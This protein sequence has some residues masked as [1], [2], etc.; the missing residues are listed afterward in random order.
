[1]NYAK[2]LLDFIQKSPSC[3]HAIEN[4]KNQLMEKG[5]T[6]LYEKED[7]PLEA[8]KKYFVRRN[9][10]AIISFLVPEDF[11]GFLITASHSDSPTF[12]IKENPE[13]KSE[14]IISL[15]V[16]KYGG[17][18]IAPWFD[19]PLSIAGRIV[20]SSKDKENC[21]CIQEK[22]I[23]FD[24]DL[25]MIPNL[26][27]HMNR[28]A[29]SGHEFDVQQ[30][31]RPIISSEEKFSFLELIAKEAGVKKEEILSYDLYL[32]NRD[33]GT[34]WGKDKE[35]ISSPKLDDLE[36]AYTVLQGFIDAT[37]DSNKEIFQKNKKA[38]VYSVFDNEEVGSQSRQGAASTFL[39]DT[40]KRINEIFGRS[41][42]DYLKALANSF[43]VSA[44]N[45]H[46]VHPNYASKADPNNKP[47]VNAGPVIK[48]NAAQKYTSDALSSAIF[49]KVCNKAKLPYQIFTN[50]S[51]LAGG[52]T[53]GNISESQVSI[54][55]VD[56][57]LAQWAMHSPNESGGAKD[58]ELMI[59]AISEYYKND[60]EIQ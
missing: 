13:L 8:G 17:M 49:K 36:C 37:E 56:I 6:E 23:N 29:N 35:F 30:E 38:L 59:K 7:W 45:A 18:L 16:E 57:G 55:S 15:N 48:F 32:Y 39:K 50:N 54:L 27:I 2:N 31:I 21:L 26:A 52:S 12:K 1:M 42:K 58:V 10:S 51:N 41:E 40:L 20:L 22:L 33:K 47:Q 4:I 43:L 46:A 3:F 44:D 53:L 28:D 60:I 14:G 25:L 9:N 5:F 19:R 34:F 24:R 11:N